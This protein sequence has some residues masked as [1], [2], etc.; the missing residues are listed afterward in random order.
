MYSIVVNDK[1]F[2]G[3]IK[4]MLLDFEN[5]PFNLPD[6]TKILMRDLKVIL[7]E[8]VFPE[9]MIAPRGLITILLYYSI[10][11]EY[12]IEYFEE[13]VLFF[14]IIVTSIVMMIG[15]LCYKKPKE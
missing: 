8:N 9:I 4:E 13:G 1:K 2:F 6:D 10:P 14:I 7:K 12:Q 11:K 15:L 3:Y 5:Y